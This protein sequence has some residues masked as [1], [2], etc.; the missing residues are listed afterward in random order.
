MTFQPRVFT[1]Y[2]YKGGVGRSMA[3]LN[4]AYYLHA[5]GRHVL[6][7]DLDLDAPG[8]SGFLHRADELLPQQGSGDVV[9]VLAAIVRSVTTVPAGTEPPLPS[10]RLEAFLRS[11]NP[12]KYAT[13]VH[14][15]AP[16]ARLDVLAADE[17][18]DYTTRLSALELP[19]LSAEKIT[20]AS[21]LLRGILL[22]HSFPFHQPW[23]EEG[24]PPENTA[25]D[26]ILVD[27]RTGFSE[28]GGLC[29]GPLSDRLVVLC[30]LNDQNIAG[31]R[32]FLDLVGLKR[33]VRPADAAWDDADASD[34]ATPRPATLGP[35]PT[36]L[37]ASPVPGGE[38]TYKRE[39]MKV[40]ESEIGLSPVKLSY[41]PQMALMETIFVRDHADEYLALEYSTLAK[42]L[43][44]M[45]ADTSEQLEAPLYR[46]YAKRRSEERIN[47]D[48][49]DVS[50]RLAR[51]AL[52]GGVVD[53][54][55]ILYFLQDKGV[56]ARLQTQIR[57][58]QIQLAPTD[59]HAAEAWL[60]WADELDTEE[61]RKAADPAIFQSMEDKYRKAL[62]LKPDYH[63][64]LSNWGTA[65]SDWAN[66][67]EG[68][69]AD[70]LFEQA[71]KKFQ[72]ALDIKPDKYEALINWGATLLDWAKKHE[73]AT[74]NDFLA[75]AG[76]KLR[77]ALAIKPDDNDALFNVA[78]LSGL[79]GDLDGTVSA[80][81]RWKAV[82]PKAAKAALDGDK[83][84]DR[85]RNDPRFQAFRE[86]LPD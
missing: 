46:L 56:S 45:V 4:M 80:L 31:T 3:L 15:K 26:Y 53:F 55:G 42:R 7:V 16:R 20:Q 82:F 40:L 62:A 67:K 85:V 27:S 36:L 64:A 49:M 70:N 21:D 51:I 29:I 54:E 24:E 83:D 18:R 37:V 74:A 68:V 63:A 19:S 72:Q 66:T 13:A 33:K 5:R 79:H 81:E 6:I 76:E 43:M 69:E 84:F 59:A 35:K 44:G 39:R 34:F 11:V 61:A 75:Q 30:G 65:L 22:G 8:A 50:H 52:A 2:S 57:N 28:I 14:P 12:K 10:L 58:T 73:G 38:M 78:C 60:A 9:D 17:T 86:R 48:A 77:Q 25:Y 41:H 47:V 32:Q 1:F 23:R 71:Q